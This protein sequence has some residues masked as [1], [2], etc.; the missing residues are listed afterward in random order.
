MKNAAD[1]CNGK[2]PYFTQAEAEAVCAN[3]KS[4]AKRTGQGGRSWRRLHVYACGNHFHIGRSNSHAL[5]KPLP[6]KKIPTTGE[7]RRK[8]KRVEAAIDGAQRH[9]AFLLGQIIERDRQR[10]YQ[11]ALDAIGR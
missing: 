2:E 8:L 11:A 5:L 10:D 6:A 3:L 7:L 4:I 9:R 1:K